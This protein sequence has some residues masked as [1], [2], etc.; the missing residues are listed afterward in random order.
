[1]DH[2]NTPPE[3]RETLMVVVIYKAPR[4]FQAASKEKK[5]KDAANQREALVRDLVSP[6]RSAGVMVE[7]ASQRLTVGAIPSVIRDLTGVK[8]AGRATRAEDAELVWVS[9][10]GQVS[11]DP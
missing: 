10:L 9:G 2:W 7:L 1:M 8:I 6:G 5:D 3:R 11:R 4:I